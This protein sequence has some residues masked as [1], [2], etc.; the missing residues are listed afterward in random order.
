MKEH[1]RNEYKKAENE[2]TRLRSIIDGLNCVEYAPFTCGCYGEA[3][4]C[5]VCKAKREA[6]GE[7]DC[8]SCKE[9]W[10]KGF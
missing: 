3:E 8:E 1:P 2:V 9:C 4:I 5:Q 6:V 7:C 10:A